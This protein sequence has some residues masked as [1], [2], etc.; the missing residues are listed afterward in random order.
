MAGTGSG[1]RVGKSGKAPRQAA[2]RAKELRAQIQHH[3][4]LYYALGE[5]EIP[6]AEYDLLIVELR[7]LESDHPEIATPDSP[8][9]MVG[10]A[11]Q[12]GLFQEVRHRVPM[13]SLDNAFSEDEL[14]AWSERLR[15]AVPTSTSPCSRSRRSRRSTAWPCR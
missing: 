9:H 1:G 5:P 15:R 13:M 3:N 11:A 14:R 12:S 10:A 4:E 2:A 6:D 8:T 7:Q